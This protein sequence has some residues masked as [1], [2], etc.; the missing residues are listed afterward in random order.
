MVIPPQFDG[1]WGFSGGL[2]AVKKDRKWGYIDTCGKVVIPFQFDFAWDF[3]KGL[4]KLWIG[5]KFG[6]VDN[7]GKFIWNPSE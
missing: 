1:A 3:F 4:G 7:T 6:Y 2:A 5:K